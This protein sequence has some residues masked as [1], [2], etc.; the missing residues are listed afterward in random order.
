MLVRTL[1]ALCG[2]LLSASLLAA[3]PLTTADSG[4]DMAGTNSQCNIAIDA[5]NGGSYCHHRLSVMCVQY[6][7]GYVGSDQR[8]DE[9]FQLPLTVPLYRPPTTSP[10]S[11]AVLIGSITI[12][13][14]GANPSIVL[15]GE[16]GAWTRAVAYNGANGCDVDAPPAA[17]P[18]KWRDERV[19]RLTGRLCGD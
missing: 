12:N 9:P 14:L 3:P 1:A 11:P 5:V 6:G 2:L 17:P 7:V 13:A 4:W 10:Y 18:P 16:H 19:C 8:V 15:N